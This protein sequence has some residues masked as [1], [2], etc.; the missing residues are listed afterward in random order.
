MADIGQAA[1]STSAETE[2]EGVVGR[3]REA[4]GEWR[5]VLMSDPLIVEL[6]RQSDDEV[7][8]AHMITQRH[9]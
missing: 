8:F 5:D 7:G 6:I 2:G 4:I 1:A 3:V 9:C